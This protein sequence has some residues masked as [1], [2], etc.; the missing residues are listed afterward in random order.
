MLMENKV[1]RAENLAAICEPIVYQSGIL[2]I[3][4]L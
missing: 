1:R 2:N 3:S 4:T